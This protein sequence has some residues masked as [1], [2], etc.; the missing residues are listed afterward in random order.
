MLTFL[1]LDIESRNAS[2]FDTL[3]PHE[4]LLNYFVEDINRI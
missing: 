3:S 2:S 4:Y 1:R